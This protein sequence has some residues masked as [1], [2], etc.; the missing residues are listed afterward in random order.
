MV[1]G[2]IITGLAGSGKTLLSFSLWEWFKNINQDVAI[3]NLDPGAKNLPYIP[4][5]DIREYIN[6]WELME[7]HSIGPN[8]AL[9]LSMDLLLDYV[10]RF[11]NIIGKTNP[12]LLIIDTPGQIEYFAYRQ[13]SRFFLDLLKVE[14]KMIVFIMDALFV[15]DPRNLIS[16]LMVYT[17]VK[18]RFDYP[19]ILVLN[20][21]DLLSSN[22]RKKINRWFRASQALFKEL[23]RHYSDDEAM[24]LIKLYNLMKTYGLIF[25]YIPISSITLDNID[26]LIQAITRILFQ[27]EEY[28]EQ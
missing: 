5:I 13:S 7:K 10:E 6:L 4:E 18:T 20:K 3:F 26:I 23:I 22:E 27:G 12:K 2:I 28:L 11:N 24:L 21:V 14:E 1:K 8:G 16:N 15:S 19:F 25:N 17:S 9:I